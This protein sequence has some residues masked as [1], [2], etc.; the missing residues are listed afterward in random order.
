MA[1]TGNQQKRKKPEHDS[2]DNQVKSSV[3]IDVC[4]HCNKKCSQKG[5]TL[6]CDLCGH[7][8]HASCEGIKRD[9]YRQLSQL[10][11]SL[12]NIYHTIVS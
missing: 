10:V 11:S 3:C 7:W 6:Q 1:M 8:V 2:P 4:N 5:E 12:Q 9:Q